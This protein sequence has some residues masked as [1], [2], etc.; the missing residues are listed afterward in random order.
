MATNFGHRFYG[1]FPMDTNILAFSVK[2]ACRAVGCGRT[3][4]YS[5]ISS[6]KIEARALGGRTIIPAES[7]QRFMASLPPAPIRLLA[8]PNQ[9]V[10]K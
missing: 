9:G 3:T 1:A 7:L 5:L 8:A 10:E 6:G 4:L 2:D